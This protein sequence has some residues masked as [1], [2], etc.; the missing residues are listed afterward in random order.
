MFFCSVPPAPS[1]TIASLSTAVRPEASSTALS[2]AFAGRGGRHAAAHRQRLLG[3]DDVDRPEARALARERRHDVG[4]PRGGVGGRDCT[5][6]RLST[7]S[8][9]KRSAAAD[10]IVLLL[11]ASRTGPVEREIAL[12][13]RGRAACPA[14]P[15]EPWSAARP[16]CRRRCVSDREHDQDEQR[17]GPAGENALGGHPGDATARCHAQTTRRA[18]RGGRRSYG[19][20]DE[21]E[22]D[23]EPTRSSSSRTASRSCAPTTAPGRSAR[24]AS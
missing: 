13:R 18:P 11:V 23:P 4:E 12:P 20:A 16:S 9:P 3:R 5:C 22:A 17:G 8:L 24:G 6:R 10:S 15:A 2:S 14:P 21:S 7:L 19:C 1:P